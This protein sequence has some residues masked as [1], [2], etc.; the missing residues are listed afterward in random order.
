MKD[1]DVD[2]GSESGGH[3]DKARRS[4]PEKFH[5]LPRGLL[6][7]SERQPRHVA[8]RSSQAGDQPSPDGIG[9]DGHHDRNRAGGLLCCSDRLRTASHDDVHSEPEQLGGKTG[10]PLMVSLGRA[11]LDR[12]V[13]P[14]DVAEVS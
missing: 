8:P 3:A 12:E 14:L 1:T 10:E 2:R 7:G 6:A 5:P 9:A 13:L 11:R 4:L